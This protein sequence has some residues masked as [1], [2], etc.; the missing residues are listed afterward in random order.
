VYLDQ[1]NSQVQ[2]STVQQ[3]AGSNQREQNP[4]RGDGIQIEDYHND[5]EESN[6][7]TIECGEDDCRPSL[8]DG[9]IRLVGGRQESEG[10]LEI[11]HLGIWGSVCDDEWDKSEAQIVCKKLGFPGAIAATHGSRYGYGLST[12]WMDNMYCYG[13]EE[14]ITDCRFDGWGIHDCDRSE[15]AGVRCKPLPPPTTTTTTT[16]PRPKFPMADVA[17]DV[18]IRLQGGRLDEEGRVELSFDGGEWGVI[19]GDGWGVREAMVACRQL[20]M[21]YL[22]AAFATDIF[23]GVN[24]TRVISGIQCKG[25][26]SKHLSNMVSI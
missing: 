3:D 2:G 18:N 7:N 24:M 14:H 12:T 17:K 15:A 10:N 23:G 11:Y 8:P 16:T 22:A 13:T 1:V 19:C 9:S 21:T 20:G 6:G 4:V 26:S 25:N 5:E